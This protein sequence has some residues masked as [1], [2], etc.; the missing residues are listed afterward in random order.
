MSIELSED[1][2]LYP[3]NEIG[4]TNTST[5]DDR[6]RVDTERSA[7]GRSNT[8]NIEG[9]GGG[10]ERRTYTSNRVEE[11]DSEEVSQQA[12]NVPTI[13]PTDSVPNVHADT[14][15]DSLRNPSNNESDSSEGVYL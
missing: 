13:D 14:I 10:G 1:I 2:D 7:I 12:R 3:I 11:L 6:R 15:S 9:R 4:R 5:I 8:S